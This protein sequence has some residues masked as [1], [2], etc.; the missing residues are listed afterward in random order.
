MQD[1]VSGGVDKDE[2]EMQ[3]FLNKREYIFQHLQCTFKYFLCTMMWQMEN[4]II[5]F[6]ADIKRVRFPMLPTS[7]FCV[8]QPHFDHIQT[9]VVA[10]IEFFIS[11]LGQ[12]YFCW[13]H[14]QPS[15]YFGTII[16]HLNLPMSEG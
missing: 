11:T 16:I 12:R 5:C 8:L 4:L 10:D 15:T 14:C 2:K 7:A 1:A 9:V 3:Q 13:I 6:K